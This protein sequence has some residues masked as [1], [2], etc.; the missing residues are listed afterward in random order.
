MIKDIG[1]LEI[2]KTNPGSSIQDLGR[3]G[4]GKWGIPISGV[5]DQRSY[6]WL[7]HLLKNNPNAAIL[8]ILQPGFKCSFDSFTTIGLAGAQAEVKKNGELI[9]SS[10]IK[11]KPGDKLEIGR[12]ILG[13]ILYLGIA[14]GFQMEEILD[15]RSFYPKITAPSMLSKGEKI[16][17]F[18]NQSEASETF[19]SVKTKS[20]WFQNKSLTVYPGPDFDSL[21]SESQTS[22]LESDFTISTLANRMAFQLEELMPN[23]I[24][25]RMTAPVYPGT[26]QLTSG[27]KLIILMRDA[28][29]TG[30]YPRIL[31]LAEDSISILA[32]K[33]PGHHIRFHLKNFD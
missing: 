20:D 26:I 10:I 28:Q 2:L 1:Y 30:G 13:S 9:L 16:P 12:F 29:T 17:F 31:Q 5:M 24:P 4:L 18:T 19:S 33:K 11:I 22:L 8:E 7:N 23:S 15:S 14:Q 32:Q 6:Q 25:E 27:G 21:S 3:I